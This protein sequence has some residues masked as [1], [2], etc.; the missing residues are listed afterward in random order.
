MASK[1]EMRLT[2]G[3][4]SASLTLLDP[5]GPNNTWSCSPGNFLSFPSGKWAQ[6]LGALPVILSDPSDQH[7]V[8]QFD[9]LNMFD[10]QN[11][12]QSGDAIASGDGGTVGDTQ[13]VAW[14]INTIE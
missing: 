5:I 2:W 11:G 6:G 10:P 14:Q 3:H 9:S 7:N 13:V 12:L 8:L 4:D 1:V